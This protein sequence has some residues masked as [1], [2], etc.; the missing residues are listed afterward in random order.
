[1]SEQSYVYAINPKQKGLSA[2][3]YMLKKSGDWRGYVEMMNSGAIESAPFFRSMINF[4]AAGIKSFENIKPIHDGILIATSVWGTKYLGRFLTLCLPSLLEESN[5]SALKE[6]KA[7]IFIHTNPDGQ[8]IISNH[9]IVDEFIRS[10]IMVQVMLI[11]DEVLEMIETIPHAKYW[12][13]GMTQSMH[14][15]YAKALD[16]DYHLMMPD[17]VYSAGYFE[18]LFNLRRQVITHGC[19]SCCESDMPFD[20][21]R[22]GLALS[23]PAVTL[24]TLSLMHAHKRADMHFV[25][26]SKNFPRSHLLIFEGKDDVSIMAP[27][28]SIAFLSKKIIRKIPDRIFFTLDSELDKIVGDAYIYTPNA[29]DALVMSEVSGEVEVYQRKEARDVAEYCEVFRAR[30]P[31]KTLYPIFLQG[32]SFPI[33]RT[34]LGDRWYMEA[35]EIEAMKK[36]VKEALCP[37]IQ[38]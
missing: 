5:L 26:K 19:I 9:P 32:M 28:Q 15:Q 25:K 27:H 21:Y 22:N 23:I 38:K 11:N 14:L 7:R 3:E 24:M 35:S 12:H 29:K 37:A 31:E 36:E 8:K 13:L 33:D 2:E 30:I 20:Y 1:M 16:I 6:K 4:Y 10:G 17:M 18:R 34:M